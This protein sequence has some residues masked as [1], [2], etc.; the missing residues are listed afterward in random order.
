MF[1]N[2]LMCLR[3]EIRGRTDRKALLSNVPSL[4]AL[5][6]L[7]G[8]NLQAVHLQYQICIHRQVSVPLMRTCGLRAPEKEGEKLFLLLDLL[9][10]VEK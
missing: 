2:P 8:T 4:Y 9:P 10:G 5:Q 7:K 3:H 1:L 6:A